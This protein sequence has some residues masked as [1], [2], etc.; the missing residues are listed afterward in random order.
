MKGTALPGFTRL[1]PGRGVLSL[2]VASATTH[3]N[4]LEFTNLPKSSFTFAKIVRQN[5]IFGDGNRSDFL[6]AQEMFGY[7][8]AGMGNGVEEKLR[9]G[10]II[11]NWGAEGEG[12][13]VCML[14][15]M[16]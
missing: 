3:Y 10:V 14:P 11:D 9:K 7:V 4:L 5:N 1:V 13:A 12:D 2:V 6:H 15:P 16:R 8:F